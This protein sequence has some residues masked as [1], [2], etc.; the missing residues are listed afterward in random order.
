MVFDRPFSGPQPCPP[1]AGLD[2]MRERIAYLNGLCAGTA[3]DVDLRTADAI[4]NST[5]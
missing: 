3:G 1:E 5:V 2:L 4:P